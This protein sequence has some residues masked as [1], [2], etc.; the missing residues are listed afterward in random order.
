MMAFRE[1]V[2][3]NSRS[4]I[5]SVIYKIS[6]DYLQLTQG[7]SENSKKYNQERNLRKQGTSFNKRSG[8]FFQG[9]F[10]EKED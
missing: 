8:D 9:E 5:C 10:R 4:K 1:C 7:Q 3:L 2:V 6:L